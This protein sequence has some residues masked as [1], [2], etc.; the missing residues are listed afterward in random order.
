MKMAP[1]WSRTFTDILDNMGQIPGRTLQHHVERFL[2]QQHILDLRNVVLELKQTGKESN[3]QAQENSGFHTKNHEH[4]DPQ[5]WT[6]AG[7]D[8]QTQV[9]NSFKNK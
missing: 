8:S 4:Q 3:V 9:I 7:G 6:T 1:E 2:L 5:Y